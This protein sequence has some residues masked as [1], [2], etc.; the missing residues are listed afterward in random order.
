MLRYF[1][2]TVM[3]MSLITSTIYSYDF[4]V[5]AG[6]WKHLRRARIPEFILLT[7]AALGGCYGA[8]V[9][10]KVQRHKASSDKKYFRFVIYS[11]IVM[12]LTTL[13]ILLIENS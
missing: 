7:L 12:N 1:L 9:T 11:S 2:I 5:A 3:T 6:Q 13:I 8:F 4:A 10:M